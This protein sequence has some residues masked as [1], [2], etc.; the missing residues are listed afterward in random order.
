[1][2]KTTNFKKVAKSY[3]SKEKFE[4]INQMILL[5]NFR[6]GMAKE[7]IDKTKKSLNEERNKK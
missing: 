5:A 4:S 2:F 7:I 6:I 3:L 1:M